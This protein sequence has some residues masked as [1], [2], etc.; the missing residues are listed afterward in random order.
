MQLDLTKIM[1]TLKSIISK[2]IE[3]IADK[4]EKRKKE[5]FPTKSRVLINLSE[6]VKKKR[7]HN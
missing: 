4:S 6:L 5:L 2:K 3:N 1:L 7:R